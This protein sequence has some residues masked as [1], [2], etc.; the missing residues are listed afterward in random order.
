[1]PSV[2]NIDKLF[3]SATAEMDFEGDELP[4][5]I[6]QESDFLHAGGSVYSFYRIILIKSSLNTISWRFN[7]C[8]KYVL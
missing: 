4:V 7:V 8:Q 5:A 6:I 1:V 3:P 2:E